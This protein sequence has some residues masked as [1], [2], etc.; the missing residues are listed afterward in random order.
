MEKQQI[1]ELQRVAVGTRVLDLVSKGGTLRTLIGEPDHVEANGA[2]LKAFLAY[3]DPGPVRVEESD[4][5]FSIAAGISSGVWLLPTAGFAVA[6]L[7]RSGKNS[8]K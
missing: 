3:R 4:W 2:I 7:R 1:F 8:S 5:L 6:F